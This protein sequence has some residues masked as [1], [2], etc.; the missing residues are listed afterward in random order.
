MTTPSDF[1]TRSDPPSH[2]ELLDYLACRLMSEGWS[3]KKLIRAIVVSQTYQQAS[4]DREAG[5]AADPE[6]RLLWRMNRRR[7][8]F[9][10][11]RDS[12]LVAAGRLDKTIGGPAVQIT[13][14]PFATR[15]SVYGFIDRQNL[16]GF[17]RTFDFA[18]PD[19]HTPRRP[20]TTVPQQALYMMNSPFALEQATLPGESAGGASKRPGTTS[21]SRPCSAVPAAAIRAAS[22]LASA[23]AYLKSAA[24]PETAASAGDEHPW[25]YGYGQFD[26]SAQ[27]LAAFTPL[28]HFT[29]SAWQGGPKLPDPALGWVILNAGGGH[30]GN[31]AAHAAVRRW[32]APCDGKLT[33]DGTLEHSTTKATACG[34]VVVAAARAR[35]ASGRAEQPG[36]DD[37]RVGG[38]A[39]GDT[40]DFVTDCRSGPSF[41]GFRWAVAVRLASY[42]DGGRRQW[43]RQGRFRGPQPA[44]RWR[45][46]AIGPSAADDERV[47]FVD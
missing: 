42:R 33:I 2:P 44:D 7:L 36:G 17:F 47:T 39:A 23:L 15:R 9:E 35:G 5:R 21:E 30:P 31:D 20:L 28:P 18:S 43:N 26:E 3:T 46:G 32:T 24:Q 13:E 1:G 16:P 38:G 29:G 45:L 6:N 19:A 11:L 14:P 34:A 10:A 22:E 41:D 25:R 40:I 4:D 12:L 37:G 27:R 8:D